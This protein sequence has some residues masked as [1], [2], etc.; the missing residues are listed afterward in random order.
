MG[1]AIDVSID[2]DG[3]EK[4]FSPQSLQKGKVAMMSQMMMDTTQYIPMKSGDLRASGH[5]SGN[6][7]VYDTPYARA[8][9]YGPKRKGFVTAKQRRF[10][11]ANKDKLLAAKGKYTTPG[12]GTHWYEKSLENAANI[13][14]WKKAFIEA[15]Q[16]EDV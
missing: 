12:T 4:K 11:F 2:L 9:Y 6:S 15:I 8:Q 14:K 7:I 10:F 1:K 16:I 5:I 13:R 3:I